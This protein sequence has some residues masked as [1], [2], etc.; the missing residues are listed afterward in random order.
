VEGGR[1]ASVAGHHQD[2]LVFECGNGSSPGI[3][4]SGWFKDP[5]GTT[6]TLLQ[7]E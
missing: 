4:K 7:P 3:G 5:D 2:H 1:L 6:L